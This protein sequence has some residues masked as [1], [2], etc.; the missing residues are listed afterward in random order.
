[1]RVG[2]EL[3]SEKCNLIKRRHIE[4]MWK[5]EEQKEFLNPVG[6]RS[7]EKYSKEIHK[8]NASD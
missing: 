3:G 1:M 8:G 6:R 4:K 7:E 2:A 5:G